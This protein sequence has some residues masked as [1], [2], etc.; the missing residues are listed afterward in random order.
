MSNLFF[1]NA[2]F[3]LSRT[4]F[5]R[6]TLLHWWLSALFNGTSPA[7]KLANIKLISY[8]IHEEL[9]ECQTL[10][11]LCVCY[12]L[13]VTL[14]LVG[15][16]SQVGGHFRLTLGFSQIK[17]DVKSVVFRAEIKAKIILP[18]NVLVPL[19]GGRTTTK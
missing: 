9:E 11:L 17:S 2:N 6:W 4:V 12:I 3:T 15:H 18:L 19:S 14:H 13:A 16:S 8:T 7:E 5:L 10:L 1:S